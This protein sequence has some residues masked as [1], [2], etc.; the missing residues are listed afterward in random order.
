MLFKIK[1]YFKHI[2]FTKNNKYNKLVSAIINNNHNIKYEKN[3]YILTQ[4]VYDYNYIFKLTSFCQSYASIKKYNIIVY[5]TY[6]SWNKLRNIIEKFLY[7]FLYKFIC[8]KNFNF[9]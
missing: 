2:N 9:S 8:I 5:D 7:K 4:L 6:F 3:E 1:Q